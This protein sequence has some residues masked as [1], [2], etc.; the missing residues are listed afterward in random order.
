[1]VTI[2]LPSDRCHISIRLLLPLWISRANR[3]H[4]PDKTCLGDDIK[5]TES[6]LI[7]EA[8]HGG[9]ERR[10]AEACRSGWEGL[11]AKRADAQYTHGQS[12]DWLKLKCVLGYTEP[13]GSRSEFGGR[14]S[15]AT[16]KEAG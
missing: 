4:T 13:A 9:S 7:S 1:L 6:L 10:F 15:S 3:P 16:T 14:C 11:I 5:P 12:R 8:W 2:S